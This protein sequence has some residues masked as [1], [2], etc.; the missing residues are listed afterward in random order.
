MDRIYRRGEMYYAE[1]DSGTGS[2][3]IGY[4]PVLILQNDVGNRYSP[5]VIVAAISSKKE[6]KPSLKTHYLLQPGYGIK[7][8]SIVL[9]EQLRTID[10]RRLDRYIGRLPSAQMK[11]IDHALS[12]SLGIRQAKQE[13]RHDKQIE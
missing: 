7:V 3:Q 4:R 9:L 1:L 13:T 10:K 5:T 2:E 8:P 12:I 6:K 11:E